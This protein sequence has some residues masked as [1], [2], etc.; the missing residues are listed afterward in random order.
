MTRGA[1][2]AE[3]SFLCYWIHLWSHI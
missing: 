1:F 3:I 2:I